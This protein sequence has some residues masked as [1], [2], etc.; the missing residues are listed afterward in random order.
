MTYLI[1]GLII[2]AILIPISTIVGIEFYQFNRNKKLL[3]EIEENSNASTLV[4]YFSRSGNT[5]LM[6]NE[7]ARI[8]K[9]DLLTIE[10]DEYKIGLKGWIESLRDARN[11]TAQII[12]EKI[13]L[14]RYDT[15][16][17][18]SPI[19]LYSPAPPIWEFARK[20]D[21]KSK[22][23][24]LFNSM[25]S[26]FE[27]R[28]IDQYEDVIEQNGGQF[29]NHIYIIR[30]RMTQQM[31]VDDFIQEIRNKLSINQP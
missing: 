2:L 22:S 26:K 4:I 1:L 23:V 25:N 9:A 18:G 12:P 3:R 6:A 20:N 14:S 15:I 13:D 16:Y 7:I 11:T 21:F 5:E 8:K 29:I 28:F 19:W 30:G 17:I 10:A 24:I 27:Q 31:E